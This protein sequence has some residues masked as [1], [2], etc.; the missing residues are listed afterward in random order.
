MSTDNRTLINDCEAN[1]GWTGDDTANVISTAG[2][3]IQGSAALATQL[4]NSDEHMFTTQDSVG[5]GTFSLDWSDSTLYMVIKDNLGAAYSA[6]GI[7]FVVSDGTNDIGYDV[8]GNDAA[9]MPYRLGFSAFKLDVSEAITTPGG[10]TNFAGTEA[11]LVHS[12]ST[13]IGYG[14][15]HLAKAV[16]SI[17]NVIMDGFYHITNDSYALTV[18]G[19]TIGTP[20][21]MA[22]VAT[23]DI[24]NGWALVTNPLGTQYQFFGP[25]EWGESAAA[26]DH[27][28]TASGEQWYWIGDNAGGRAIAATHM[29]F[30][31]TA[32]ATDAGSFVITNVAIVSTG[33]SADFDCSNTDIDILEIDTC[34]MSGL[35]TFSSPTVGGTSR[36]CTSTIFSGCGVIT[37]NGAN[38][39]DCTVLSPTVAADVGSVSY[40][41]ATDPDTVTDGMSFEMGTASHH[42]IDFGTSV[43]S[44]I[45][46]RNCNFEG[47]GSTDDANDSTVRFLAT[48]GSI[49]LSLVGCTVD[50]VDA[51]AANFSVDDAAGITVSLIISPVTVEVSTIEADG[52]IIVSAAVLLAA[53]DGTGPFPFED[54]VTIARSGSVATVTHTGHGMASNDKV[55]I[56][57]DATTEPEYIG[58]KQITFV[59]V[60]SYS[61]TVSGTPTTP[62]SGTITSTFVALQGT[63]DG[64]TGVLST[65]RVYGSNQPVVGWTRKS[66]TAPYY[67]QG[68]LTGEISSSTGYIVS[69][70]MPLDQ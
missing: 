12:T 58:V 11:S 37:H 69:A 48:S 68:S 2:S 44:N 26:A 52:T 54:S 13:G 60:N 49:N 63:T 57:G 39:S 53:S 10:F 21:T 65:T 66:S 4:S 20:E 45:T 40:N 17:D 34:S 56:S 50:G 67:K 62:A 5:A 3:F 38:M 42:A 1:T 22:D 30:R 70:V 8:A 18:N 29:P 31:V 43:T 27:Y 32:N 55:L 51:S 23:D 19:G 33:T 35:E 41:L 14:S 28:F 15:I 16:G 64:V 47:F 59:D 9:G 7:Q 61:Y 6:G 46:L 24:T 36:F 25:T